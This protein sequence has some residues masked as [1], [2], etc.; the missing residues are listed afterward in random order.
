MQKVL[1]LLLCLALY[2]PIHAQV[3]TEKT[4]KPNSRWEIGLD[5]LPFFRPTGQKVVSLNIDDHIYNFKGYLVLKRRLSSRIKLR[6]K[7]AFNS[8][9]RDYNDS[10]DPDE[11]SYVYKPV[12]VSASIGAEYYYKT[13]RLSAYVG[14]EPRYQYNSLEYDYVKRINVDTFIL[15]GT[16]YDDFHSTRYAIEVPLGFAYNLSHQIQ[17]ALELSMVI[18][19][20]EEKYYGEDFQDGAL[21]TYGGLDFKGRILEINPISAFHLM[22]QF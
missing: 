1:L 16:G 3:T 5:V 11:F 20:F 6:S 18:G 10:T 4:V 14:I 21:Y 15:R 22:F 13:G 7:L 19:K 2:C 8:F 17:I 9:R 12:K